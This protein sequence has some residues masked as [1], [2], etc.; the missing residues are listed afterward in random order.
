MEDSDIELMAKIVSQLKYSEW[1][2]VCAAIE[3]KYS[4]IL[5]KTKLVNS[6]EIVNAI[7]LEL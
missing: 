3:K 5:A 2:R 1:L 7:K 4:S 6:E